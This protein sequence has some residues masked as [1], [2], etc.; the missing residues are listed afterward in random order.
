MVIRIELPTEAIEPLFSALSVIRPDTCT[1]VES[2]A[3]SLLKSTLY[4][5]IEKMSESVEE[6]DERKE[7][8]QKLF[9]EER[10]RRKQEYLERWNA[11]KG[12]KKEVAQA[13]SEGPWPWE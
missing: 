10:E 2:R 1:R 13:N 5:E 6:S 7:N 11:N 3:V 12:D 9:S 8:F 4:F